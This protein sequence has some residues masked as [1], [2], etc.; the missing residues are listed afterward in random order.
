MFTQ[1]PTPAIGMASPKAIGTGW[2]KRIAASKAINRAI[3]ASTTALVK[4]ARSPSLPVPKLNL[5]SRA[6]RRARPYASAA[7]SK[8]PAWVD[9]CRPSAIRAMEPKSRPP[10]ISTT[11]KTPQR[12]M[13]NQVRRSLRAWSGARKR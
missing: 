9:I 13:T 1:R 10:A 4:P 11:M 7:S 3:I 2:R 6:C 8:A 5:V 12:P